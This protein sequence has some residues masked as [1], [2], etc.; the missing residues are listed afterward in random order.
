[1]VWLKA[2]R[3]EAD[4]AK[5]I[6]FA[7]RFL[8][9]ELE[10]GITLYNTFEN[11]ASNYQHVGMYF[12]MIAEKVRLGTGI[13]DAIS[14]TIEVCPS[15]DLRKILWQILNSIKTGADLAFALNGVLE[16]IVR[17][18]KIAVKEYGNKLNPLAMFYMMT[19][20]IMPSL[21]VTMLIVLSSFISLQLSLTILLV[22][23]GFIGLLQVMFLLMIRNS[24]PN[25]DM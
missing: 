15:E 4:V 17:E 13:D 12:G 23:A 25:V 16:N 7:G 19:A 8:V 21:G 14:E 5:E 18:Q 11:L 2:K 1:M 22:L 3:I 9:I 20:I 10:S 6:V 24:R